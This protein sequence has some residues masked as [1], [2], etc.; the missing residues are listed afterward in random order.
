[1]VPAGPK[2]KAQ[3]DYVLSVLECVKPKLRDHFF[4]RDK[5]ELS[6]GMHLLAWAKELGEKRARWPW[7]KDRRRIRL[8]QQALRHLERAARLSEK[9]IGVEKDAKLVNELTLNSIRE[10]RMGLLMAWGDAGDKRALE[11]LTKILRED[12]DPPMRVCAAM[13]LGRIGDERA[14]GPLIEALRD[15]SKDVRLGAAEALGKLGSKALPA[16]PALHKA[17]LERPEDRVTMVWTVAEIT[18]KANRPSGVRE[19]S[20]KPEGLSRAAAEG[21]FFK[22]ARTARQDY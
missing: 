8:Y 17:A 13:G 3:L 18:S 5:V 21:S 19:V 7:Y 10:A 12:A 4:R 20:E 16:L 22:K 15:E 14:V 9:K 2:E 11:P 1:M 6:E